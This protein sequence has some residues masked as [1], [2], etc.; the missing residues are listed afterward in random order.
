LNAAPPK[1][2]DLI[3]AQYVQARYIG[4]TP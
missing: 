1:Y 4:D 3:E 2:Q